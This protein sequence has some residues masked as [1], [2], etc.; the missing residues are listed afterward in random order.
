MKKKIRV[1]TLPRCKVWRSF[2]YPG[3]PHHDEPVSSLVKYSTISR[4]SPLTSFS[5]PPYTDDRLLVSQSP[6]HGGGSLLSI[7]TCVCAIAEAIKSHN[8]FA[9][10]FA[11]SASPLPDRANSVHYFATG[12]AFTVR[13]P[14]WAWSTLRM[15]FCWCSAELG[16]ISDHEWNWNLSSK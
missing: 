8:G 10:W 14:S 5:L 4:W 7:Q 16:Q 15:N 1:G 13:L 2:V 11:P 9:S 6:R 3:R 12:G